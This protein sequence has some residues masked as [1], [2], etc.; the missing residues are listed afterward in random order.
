RV[1]LNLDLILLIRQKMM[2]DEAE[3]TLDAG[4]APPLLQAL[5]AVLSAETWEDA[6]Q[7]LKAHPELLT[8]EALAALDE[9]IRAAEVERDRELIAVFGEH[10][11]LLSRCR[12]IGIDAALEEVK[13]E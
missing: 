5:W 3:Q 1:F 12:E 13:K 10:R 6:G 11:A 7:A 4:Q 8:D 9:F 2:L